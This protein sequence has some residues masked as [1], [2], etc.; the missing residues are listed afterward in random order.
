M[1]YRLFIVIIFAFSPLLAKAYSITPYLEMVKVSNVSN[2]WKTLSLS[3]TY[4]DPIVACTYNLSSSANNEGAVRIKIVSTRRL[5]EN[6]E[7]TAEKL[8]LDIFSSNIR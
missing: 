3:N 4:T 7:S 2:A 6:R 1:H 8:D 5:S